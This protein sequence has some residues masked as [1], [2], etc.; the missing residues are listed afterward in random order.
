MIWDVLQSLGTGLVVVIFL[1][2]GVAK[3]FAVKDFRIGLLAIPRM[4]PALTY[5]IAWLLPPGEL[6]LAVGLFLDATW[7]RPS[8]ILLFAVFNG[9][10]LL[11]ARHNL[12]LDCNCFGKIGA[13]KLTMN[14]FVANLFLALPLVSGML[15][16]TRVLSLS[17]LCIS[18]CLLLL[19]V[20]LPLLHENKHMLQEL[21]G[22]S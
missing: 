4:R 7:A 10:I 20:G 6:V 21:Y 5:P 16:E 19:W 15:W 1:A 9:V 12:E 11:A 13:R 17:S 2:S 18:A 3:L 8:A 14:T 22:V